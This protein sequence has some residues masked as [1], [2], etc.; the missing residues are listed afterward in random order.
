MKEERAKKS[1]K[2]LFIASSAAV[3]VGF[4]AMPENREALAS[5]PEVIAD[6]LF[7]E[8]DPACDTPQERPLEQAQKPLG[9]LLADFSVQPTEEI[10]SYVDIR[11][12]EGLDLT[13][14]IK[15]TENY[16]RILPPP[17]L[18]AIQKSGLEINLTGPIE[19][20]STVR[21]QEIRIA[22]IFYRDINKIVLSSATFNE[23]GDPGATLLHELAHFMH[24][25]L[26]QYNSDL[27]EGRIVTGEQKLTE[28][29]LKSFFGQY[30]SLNKT[31]DFATMFEAVLSLSRQE[32]EQLVS[33]GEKNQSFLDAYDLVR[34]VVE[35][36]GFTEDWLNRYRTLVAAGWNPSIDPAGAVATLSQNLK[37]FEDRGFNST[38]LTKEDGRRVLSVHISETLTVYIQVAG[39]DGNILNFSSMGKLT[40]FARD[41]SRLGEDPS[42]DLYFLASLTEAL[43]KD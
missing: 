5:V 35:H 17:M 43:S 12:E 39:N 16:I 22:G 4:F 9:D 26:C 15:G 6:K 34:G 36:Y 32:A 13:E 20:K 37:W 30:G 21:G 42:E 3:L 38:A 18:K 23:L 40:T 24:Y 8:I 19:N 28:E 14:N 7:K 1:L 11:V 2:D 27:L 41:G 33:T 25:D 10:E 29:Q 31:E